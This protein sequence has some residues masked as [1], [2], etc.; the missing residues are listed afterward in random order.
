MFKEY[1]CITVSIAYYDVVRSIMA[2]YADGEYPIQHKKGDNHASLLGKF[3][4]RRW[5]NMLHD[6]MLLDEWHEDMEL[7]INY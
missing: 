2:R 7:K 5:N 6:L 3:K 1:H 4:E